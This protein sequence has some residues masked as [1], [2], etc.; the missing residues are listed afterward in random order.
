MT[1]STILVLALFWLVFFS[2]ILH[3]QNVLITTENKDVNQEKVQKTAEKEILDKNTLGF[4]IPNFEKS[5]VKNFQEI[6]KISC[7]RYFLRQSIECDALGFPFIAV[8]KHEGKKYYLNENGV[9]IAFD[10]RKLGLPT[11]DLVLNPIAVGK[12]TPKNDNPQQATS[13]QQPETSNQK[14]LPASGGSK[15]VFDVTVGKKI[16][17]PSEIKAILAA[18]DELEK[19]LGGKVINAQY[20]QV[21]GELSLAMRADHKDPKNLKN[22]KELTVLFDLRRDLSQQLVKLDKFKQVFDLRTIS[23]IDLSIDGEKIFYR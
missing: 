17:E 8:F 21:A 9:A 13:D 1:G 12:P 5:I 16:L 4:S 7:A 10:S 15:P 14:A 19:T 20:I 18:L 11:F 3:I 22:P 2:S 6:S 23:R